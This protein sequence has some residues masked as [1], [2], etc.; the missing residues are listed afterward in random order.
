M[1]P[2]YFS[3]CPSVDFRNSIFVSTVP[4]HRYFHLTLCGKFY[5]ATDDW[6]PIFPVS[7]DKKWYVYELNK[8]QVPKYLG[9][10]KLTK[11]LK[12]PCDVQCIQNLID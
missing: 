5:Y 4:E 12:T 10:I 2:Q 9:T 6:Q 1:N 8:S 11:K 3:K 7:K